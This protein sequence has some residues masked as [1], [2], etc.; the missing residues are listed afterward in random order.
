MDDDEFNSLTMT[1]LSRLSNFLLQMDDRGI[2]TKKDA[3]IKENK[4]KRKLENA[5]PK[6]DKKKPPPAP[7]QFQLPAEANQIERYWW[8]G[9]ADENEKLPGDQFVDRRS[10]L[11]LKGKGWID[12]R[13]IF[14]YL[15][16]VV[17]RS[18]N[19]DGLPMV[20]I[21]DRHNIFIFSG[22]RLR[23]TAPGDHQAQRI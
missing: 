18:M 20:G 13:V 17:E 7:F 1:L 16:L 23:H 3:K 12:D 21:S 10:L 19:N 9:M 6:Q 2:D 8:N 4:K 14:R 22:L 11:T 15:E 5:Q